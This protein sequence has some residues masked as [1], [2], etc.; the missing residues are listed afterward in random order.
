MGDALQIRSE[1]ALD[2]RTQLAPKIEEFLLIARLGPRARGA[3]CSVGSS[4]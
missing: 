4:R 3:R 2:A 1:L